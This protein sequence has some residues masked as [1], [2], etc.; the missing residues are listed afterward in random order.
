[1]I[2][3]GCTGWAPNAARL[4]S[5]SSIWG[6]WTQHPNPCRGEGA[7]KTFGGQSTF[8]LELP[9]E[10]FL[11]MADIWKPESLMYSGYLWLPIGFDEAGMPFLEKK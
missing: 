2:A 11:F 7:E 9:N 5:S 1:M 8:V 10:E 6:P 3:S 4:F